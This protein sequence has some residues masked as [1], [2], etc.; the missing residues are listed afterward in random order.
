MQ[1]SSLREI[2]P[3][4]K[5]T[6]II[7]GLIIFGLLLS[8]SFGERE[9]ETTGEESLEEYKARTESELEKLCSSLDGVGKCS[10]TLSFSKGAE[11]TYKSGKLTETKPPKILGVA[12]ACR[13]ADSP[14][15]RQALS[16]LFTSLFDIPS[17][18][19]AILKLN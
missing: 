18:R 1:F 9:T 12:I 5:K 14:R 16:E 15:V 17:N 3:K 2:F 8:L 4:N 11:S 7:I 13:G 10:V 6:L 19:V